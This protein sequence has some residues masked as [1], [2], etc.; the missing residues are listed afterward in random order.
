MSCAGDNYLVPGADPCINESSISLPYT[1]TGTTAGATITNRGITAINALPVNTFTLISQI[2][3]KI[4]FD[5]AAT[6]SIY[7][8]GWNLSDYDSNFNSYW[9]VTYI[10]NTFATPTEILGSITNVNN[11][12]QYSNFNQ[13][14]LPLNLIIPPTYITSGGT[15][16][17]K[18]YCNP[19]SANHYLT[20]APINN[21]RIGL[22]SN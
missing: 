13:I 7:Y 21:A 11:A 6:N 8:D 3:F 12:L 2:T 19:T 5:W 16:T 10:T 20:V 1:L 17:L 4:P 14:Y 18:I 22:V 15:I 9:G